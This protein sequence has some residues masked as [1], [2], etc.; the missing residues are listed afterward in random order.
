MIVPVTSSLAVGSIWRRWDPH[1]HFPGT[2]LNDQFRTTSV[3]DALEALAAC[4]PSIEGIGVTDYFSTRSF[5]TVTTAWRAGAGSGISYLFPNVE[6]RLND[7]TAIGKGVNLHVIA[8]NEDVDILDDLLSRLTFNF[9]DVDYLADDEGLIKLGRAFRHD[10]TLDVGAARSEGANQFKVSYEQLRTLFQRDA[11]FREHCL[12]GVAAGKDGSSGMRTDDGAFAAYRQG[13]ERFANFIFTGREL[14]RDFWLGHGVDDAA[15]IERKY[16][17]PKACL[18][19]SDAHEAAKLGNPDEDRYCWLKGDPTF[20]TLWHACL[21]PDR[22]AIVSASS[23]G[24]GQHGRIDGV[25][26]ADITWFTSGTVPI[27]TGLVAIIGPRGSGKTALAD[28]IAVGAGSPQPFENTASFVSRAGELLAE[29]NVTVSW[30]DDD[31]T[32]NSLSRPSEDGLA[33]PRRVR[34]LSQQFVERLCAADGVTSELLFEIERVIFEA[35]PVE[36]RQGATSFQELLDIRLSGARTAQRDQLDSIVEFGEE[37]TNQRVL[38]R[39]LTRKKEQRSTSATTISNL[40]AQIKDLT[41]KADA[42]SGERHAAIS[43]ALAERQKTLQAVDRKLTDLTSLRE[44]VNTARI[45]HFTSFRQQRFQQPY[46]FTGLSGEQWSAFLPEFSGDVDTIVSDAL[47][48]AQADKAAIAGVPIGANS[49]STLDSVSSDALGIHSVAELTFEQARLQKIVGLD[50]IRAATLTQLQTKLTN[51]RAAAAKLDEDI[52]AANDAERKAQELVSLRAARYEAY[53]NALLSEEQELIALYAPLEAILEGFGP[54]VSKL[55]LSVRRR[56]DLSSWVDYAERNLIDLRTSGPFRGTGGLRPIAE[57]SLL[58]AWETGD[59]AAAS[60]AIQEFS[61]TNSSALRAH[62]PA[63]TKS[64]DVAYRDWERRIARWLYGV[65][66]ISVTYNL[67]YDGLNVERLSPGSR[68]IVLLLLY[69]AVDQAETDPLIIDQP[70]ENL[71]PKSV[72]S[73]LVTLFQVASERRQIIMVTHN[74]NLVVNTDVDQV[75][76]ACCDSL[77]EGQLPKLSYQAGGLEN[78]A[79]RKAVCEILEG[80]DEAF[81]QRARRL[82]IDA[83]STKS[84]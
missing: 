15:S 57:A 44:A 56:V 54:S 35:W 82:H 72:Y 38:Q 17:G 60:A 19:G 4:S 29:S 2:L 64:D 14:D 46:P 78:P 80:G 11:K 74:A 42:A 28:L 32:S 7:A 55:K 45:S 24:T 67:E 70:E 49:S 47:I 30:H 40:E 16:G 33:G 18:H 34:Y 1:V 8:S 51:A 61:Q 25:T 68:G 53:F 71:D 43:Q 69:L 81:R 31:A 23:P 77:E 79:I 39:G 58:S 62:A 22:R 20:D 36:E 13:L 63:D 84:N 73:E 52:A 50:T 6:L 5:R 26:I 41:S 66:H 27:N 59:G 10:V 75:I 9:E 76:V 3:S 83:P 65:G 37:I 12:I 21:A 48:A